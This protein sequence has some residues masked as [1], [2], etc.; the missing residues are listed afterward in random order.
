M[1]I[2]KQILPILNNKK[3]AD[4]WYSMD[5]SINNTDIHPPQAGQYI[6]I[7]FPDMAFRRPFAISGY[8]PKKSFSILYQIRP[9]YIPLLTDNAPHN[10]NMIRKQNASTKM[11]QMQTG[12]MLDI[13]YFHGNHFPLPKS[14]RHPILVGGGVGLGPLLFFL[15]VLLS[16]GIVPTLIIGAKN[17]NLIPEV[18]LQQ[19]KS[20]IIIMTD[21]GGL[22]KKGHAIDGLKEMLSHKN[23][24]T[25]QAPIPAE[26]YFCGPLA[27]MK[28]GAAFCM[29]RNIEA[30]A[31][32][33][34][35][36]ACGVG[37]CVSCVVPL[38]D[39]R[40][41]SHR[42]DFKW[43]KICVEGPIYNIKTIVWEKYND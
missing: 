2:K 31:S 35:I 14:K 43:K 37:A 24:N 15:E 10:T 30:W 7:G 5:I 6:S 26:V 3:V 18:L 19:N 9:H 1:K 13:M 11:S 8:A 34:S 39:S 25:N 21:D 38:F 32:L 12:D 29:S 16:R 4:G 36:M 23:Q 33:E 27:M 17:K 42:A 40:T 20:S 22:G 28:T 41:D